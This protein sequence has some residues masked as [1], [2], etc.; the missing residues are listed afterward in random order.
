ML[1]IY[2]KPNCTQCIATKQFLDNRKVEYEM[3][4]VTKDDEALNV[5]SNLGYKQVPV[6]IYKTDHWSGFRPDKLIN[7][8]R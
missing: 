5:V 7:A 8:T 6:I 1:T 2:T 3:I 4:D